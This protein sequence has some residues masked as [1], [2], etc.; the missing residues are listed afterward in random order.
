MLLNAGYD[1]SYLD[2]LQGSALSQL[3]FDE[4]GEQD[5]I[6]TIKD[7]GEDEG[8]SYR[9]W[10]SDLN[11]VCNIDCKFTDILSAIVCKDLSGKEVLTIHISTPD[12]KSVSF[13]SIQEFTP[14]VAD[15]VYDQIMNYKK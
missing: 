6:D 8:D 15:R 2:T 14:E 13:V 9:I 12:D 7:K 10:L 11:G 1:Q 3:F 5:M 4:I